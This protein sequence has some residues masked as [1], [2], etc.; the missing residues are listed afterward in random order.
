MSQVQK[1]QVGAKGLAI[2]VTI[3]DEDGSPVVLDGTP[4]FH[5]ESPSE[6]DIA[7]NGAIQDADAGR[8]VYILSNGDGV[9]EEAGAWRYQVELD[10][11][12]GWSGRST[13]GVFDAV[14]NLS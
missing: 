1:I 5:F 13:I 12:S 11:S 7:V 4:V 6:T 2:V 14:A 3:V 8:A 10:L 9:G